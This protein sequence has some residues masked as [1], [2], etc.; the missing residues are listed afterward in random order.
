MT[1]TMETMIEA[2]GELGRSEKISA[3]EQMFK[4]M[5]KDLKDKPSKAKPEGEPKDKKP[6][7]WL[8]HMSYV[9][10]IM[11]EHS[12]TDAEA[13]K[14]TAM[15]GVCSMLKEA[16][17][18][19]TTMEEAAAAKATILGTF[20][21]WKVSPPP[22]KEKKEK[23]KAASSDSDS[24]GKP[25]GK[26]APWSEETK[27]K[28]AL[29]R[30]ATKAA[31]SA[32]ASV[33]SAASVPSSASSVAAPEEEEEAPAAPAAPAAPSIRSYNL[34]KPAAQLTGTPKGIRK[35][36]AYPGDAEN[37]EYL[38]DQEKD[39]FVGLYN[40]KTKTLDTS[41]EDPNEAE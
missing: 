17:S 14:A 9:R 2:F 7:P 12:K 1:D 40:T 10:P 31:K 13:K 4:L 36:E 21:R 18:Y 23:K 33:A 35:Y 34:G 38:Y 8:Q 11:L 19:F 22:P 6:N 37:T 3:M 41:V 5:K 26:R 27:A 29:K 39:I 15:T 30:A 20:A 24:E 16:G 25:K 28:A 32:T